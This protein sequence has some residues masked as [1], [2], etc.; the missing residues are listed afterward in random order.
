MNVRELMLEMSFMGG[1]IWLEDATIAFLQYNWDKMV[2]LYA[3]IKAAGPL[4]AWVPEQVLT[5]MAA[6]RKP[7]NGVWNEL[8]EHGGSELY[9]LCQA[10]SA[11]GISSMAIWH[12]A[13]PDGVADKITEFMYYV[14]NWNAVLDYQW[15]A[16]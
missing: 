6:F 1:G 12:S 3:E 4:S 7:E 2:P 5:D 16:L 15:G 8:E 13:T 10:F 9:D 14:R 11:G